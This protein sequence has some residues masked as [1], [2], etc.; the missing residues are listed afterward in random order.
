MP[1]AGAAA[2]DSA[3]FTSGFAHNVGRLR[4]FA[5]RAPRSYPKIPLA[6]FPVERSSVFFIL[7]QEKEG[8]T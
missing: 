8:C 5:L 2:A 4:R 3:S 7:V 6:P 1:L